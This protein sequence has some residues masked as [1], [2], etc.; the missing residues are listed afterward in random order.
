MIPIKFY[1]NSIKLNIVYFVFKASLCCSCG[2]TL[3]SEL[4][5]VLGDINKKYAFH[6]LKWKKV[7][8]GTN[9]GI[10]FIGTLASIVGGLIVG[11]SYY[12]SLKLFA[13]FNGN[14]FL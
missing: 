8:Q 9:G 1:F 11:L 10:T 13:C 12:S 5:P 2:D 7:P 3:A 6:I 14:L 4:G